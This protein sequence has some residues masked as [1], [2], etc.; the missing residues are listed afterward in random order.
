MH[1]ANRDTPRLLVISSVTDSY[2][3]LFAQLG[4]YGLTHLV[5][6]N[7][8]ASATELIVTIQKILRND[9]FG[10][11]KYFGWGVETTSTRIRLSDEKGAVVQSAVNFAADLD[12]HPRLVE[13]FAT[14]ADELITNAFYNAP[15]DAYGRPRF[16]HLPRSTPVE[17]PPQE[18]VVVTTCCDGQTLGVSIVDSFGA[19]TRE[20]SLHSLVNCLRNE[21]ERPD[22]NKGGA[23]I[24]LY[25]TFDS[26]NQLVLNL[27]PGRKTEVI[28]LID[29]RGN[30]RDFASRGKSFNIFLDTGSAR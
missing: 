23:G 26:L 29:V 1:A 7:R 18:A 8:E 2:E 27:A 12:V 28:G 22:R 13:K 17:L 15:V 21:G 10:I 16:A 30:Y 6:Q 3:T 19:M 14:A 5:A 20:Q 24:G 4:R 25:M 11:E 9:I